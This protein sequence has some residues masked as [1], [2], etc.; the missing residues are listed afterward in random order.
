MT[1]Q[2]IDGHALAQ[3]WLAE[4]ARMAQT[5]PHK[6]RVA[7]VMMGDNPASRAY[8]R[9]KIA[10]AASVGIEA[11]EIALRAD[12]GEAALHSVLHGLAQDPHTHGVI[13]QAPLPPHIDTHAAFDAVPWFKDVD[14]LS[15]ASRQRRLAGEPCHLPATPAAIVRLLTEHLHMNLRGLPIAVVGKGLTVGTPLREM[16]DAAG[17][18]VIGIDRDTPHPQ[19]LCRRADVVVAACGVAGLITQDWCKEG[20][21]VLDVGISRS[22]D[23]GHTALHGDVNV[24]SVDGHIG[25]R[26]PVPGGIGPLTVASLLANVV[27]AQQLAP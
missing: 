4:V 23:H 22:T 18:E 9:R 2:L 5:A 6:P 26:S 10:S 27:R 13:V 25:M 19:T 21:C 12:E 8:I 20:A 17:A 16:L 14:G 24:A 3:T 7:L 15:R 1:T 11:D